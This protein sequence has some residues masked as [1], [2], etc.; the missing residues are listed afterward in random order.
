MSAIETLHWKILSEDEAYHC[1][2]KWQLSSQSSSPFQSFYWGKIKEI[3]GWKPLYL[4]EVNSSD[5]Y[6]T[7]LL[8]L[9]KKKFFFGLLWS[10]GIP[11]GR[12]NLPN[13]NSLKMILRPMG[14]LFFNLRINFLT[15]DNPEICINLERKKFKKSW[16][17]IN[18]G[19][20]FIVNLPKTFDLMLSN[21]S[22]NWRHNLKRSQKQSLLFERWEKPNFDEIE[23]VMRH[24]ENFKQIELNVP[25]EEFK[26]LQSK[27]PEQVWFYKAT[28]QLGEILSIRAIYKLNQVVFDFL[29]FTSPEGRKNYASYGL[30]GFILKDIIDK[31][32][33]IY[34]LSGI[35]PEK[36][37]GVYNFKKGVGGQFTKYIGE[38]E[39]A[40]F[41]LLRWALNLFLWNRNRR[42]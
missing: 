5:E 42:S 26:K 31:D 15:K 37:P 7:C 2:D 12:G 36:N 6:Q 8:L 34:E 3:S 32:V 17:K 30:L 13:V 24:M 16:G 29:A 22:S 41:F 1:W 20:T 28:N 10:A 14:I 9:L 35:D 39:I 33:T 25:L 18:S 11:A 40:N 4:V 19:L 21:L 38:W 27:Y 23:R